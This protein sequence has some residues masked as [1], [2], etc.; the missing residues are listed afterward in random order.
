MLRRVFIIII[1]TE[2]FAQCSCNSLMGMLL[3]GGAVE[4]AVEFVWARGDNAPAEA[5]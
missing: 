5:F 1:E 4:E 2:V 3:T